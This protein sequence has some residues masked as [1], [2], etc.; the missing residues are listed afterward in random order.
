MSET[1]DKHI[2]I[3]CDCGCCVLRISR[4]TWGEGEHD[5]GISILDSR[6][7]HDANGIVNRVKRAA[8]ALLGR[9]VYFND[10]SLT[11]EQFD[12]LIGQ[13]AELRD[14]ANA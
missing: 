3:P 8:K 4:L 9:P 12:R 13:M 5:F 11:P 6:Y 1:N 10:L 2:Y 14:E 7:D